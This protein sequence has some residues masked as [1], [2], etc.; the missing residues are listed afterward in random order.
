MDIDLGPAS[1][2]SRSWLLVGVLPGL[3]ACSSSSSSASNTGENS[4]DASVDSGGADG[5]GSATTLPVV[6]G[7]ITG[8]STGK[9]FTA[10]P[11]DLASYGYVEQEYFF[12]GTATAY[13]WVTPPTVD[14]VWSVKTTTTASYKTR[15]L[16]R[17]P[18][19]PTKFNGTVLVEWLN[20]TGGVD[21]DPDFGY[22]YAEL[23]RSGFG[24][25]GVSAQ[26]QGVVGGGV[27]LSAL[28]GI[29]VKPLVQ[30]DPDR[31]G[32][33]QH[34][35]DDYAYDIYTQAARALRHPGAV[36]PLGGLKPA[37]LIGD[38]ESQSAIR[39]VTYVNAI[40]PIAK[41]LRRLLHPQSLQRRCAHQRV[42]G[43]RGRRDPG[44]SEPR[45][46]P[47]RPHRPGLS[48][49]DG[50]RRPRTHLGAPRAGVR[51]LSPARH[52]QPS[53]LGGR[54]DRARRPE[55]ITDRLRGGAGRRRRGRL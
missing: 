26:A 55:V 14:G 2:W 23:L 54:G 27:S 13:D 30:E 5:G 52:G 11:L 17:R 18:T 1:R 28:T 37:R 24:Y 29:A 6:T 39:M 4:T 25:V 49:R 8:G 46:H 51:G 45:A 16:V 41:R 40:H 33:L 31:Y 34:P 7:P 15:M 43:R 48:V 12:A 20:D 22:A 10:T 47:R 38:G 36:D 3:Q 32:S 21:A 53:H 19:D 42:R 44:R 35:G 50:D 9:P